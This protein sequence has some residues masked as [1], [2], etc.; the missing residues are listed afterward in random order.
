MLEPHAT[1]GRL[2]DCPRKADLPLSD[3]FSFED[4]AK[5]Y[6]FNRLSLLMIRKVPSLSFERWI[7]ETS[8]RC[9]SFS[10]LRVA[11]FLSR[12]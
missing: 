6:H 8:K 11:Q 2:T 10:Y 9:S 12:L 4:V 3:M 5:S 7:R 1:I